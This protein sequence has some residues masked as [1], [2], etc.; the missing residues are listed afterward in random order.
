MEETVRMVQSAAQAGVEI[1]AE[2][3]KIL[4]P[5]LAKGGMKLLG[6]GG[7]LL[8]YGIDKISDAQAE[9][10]VSRKHLFAEAAKEKTEVR[11]TD[12]YPQDV[13]DRLVE[14]AKENHIPVS[15]NGEGASRSISY[16]ERDTGIFAQIMQEWQQE[17][18]APKAGQQGIKAFSVSELNVDAVKNHL[19][20]NGV[21]CWFTQSKNGE[22][23]CNFSA[24][25]AEKVNTLMTDFK[26]TRSEIEENC[27]ISTNI[28]ENERQFEIK[29]QIAEIKETAES[30]RLGAEL[31]ETPEA[32]DAAL[33]EVAGELE[34]YEERI[35]ELQNEYDA[36][37]VNAFVRS[38][39]KEIIISHGEKSV[40]LNVDG[41]LHKSD[42][43]A[44]MREDLLYSNVQAELAANKLAAEI[45]LSDN[46]F[47]EP[48][49]TVMPEKL[50][51]NIRYGSDDVSIRD[52][53]FSALKLRDG[54]NVR[55]N[56]TN[57]DNSILIEPAELSDSELKSV[58]KEQLG[59]TDMQAEMA[60]SKA[61]RIDAQIQSKLRETVYSHGGQ[62]S[63]DIERTSSSSFIVKAGDTTKSYD[64]GQI[65][66]EEKIA[67]DFKLPA[68]NAHRVVQ[69]AQ[70]QSTIQN[71]LRVNAEKKRKS[72]K[73]KN[74]PFKEQ[75]VN[76]GSKKR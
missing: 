17:R 44:A 9:G 74:D 49:R 63:V 50:M 13:V 71:K 58:F 67:A 55:L 35:A 23:H 60:V 62:R 64:F 16:L 73:A 43:M 37:K 48:A 20:Q 57:G 42:V 52:V 26:K 66:L 36:E 19:E 72:E 3:L 34:G 18:L 65:N 61:R 1:T 70:G 53:S 10:T 39:N 25:N 40:T 22:I 11:C 8:G 2:L 46:Y 24:E 47:A 31:E 7:K 69:K 21:E 32:R 6:A 5:S 45:G 54:E 30:L 33:A 28:P 75:K 27:I 38:E 41:K 76:T 51:V 12:S 56:V 14:K 4:L 59:M 15:V 68:E 29:A